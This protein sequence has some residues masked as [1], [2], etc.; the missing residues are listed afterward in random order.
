MDGSAFATVFLRTKDAGAAGLT[1]LII[2]TG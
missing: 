1:C 2:P